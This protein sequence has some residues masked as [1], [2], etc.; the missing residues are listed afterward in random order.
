[1]IADAAERRAAVSPRA[2]PNAPRQAGYSVVPDEGL[3]DEVAGLV[4]WPVALLGRIDDR[5]M[6]LPP[7]VRQ[8][9]MR[10]NQRYFALT[11]A[12]GRTRPRPSS[13]PPISRPRMAA[14]PSSHGNERVLRAR[15]SDARHF[16]DL[17][18][19]HRL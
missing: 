2:L 16:W 17:D 5:F 8:V 6:D 13:S 11:D 3:L 19:A 9:S 7:E 10:V 14:R 4:E 12:D 1:M 15:L 18:R